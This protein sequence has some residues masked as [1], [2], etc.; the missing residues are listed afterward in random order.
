MVSETRSLVA[1][2]P[3]HFYASLWRNPKWD[4]CL[5]EII[6]VTTYSVISNYIYIYIHI[7]SHTVA[8]VFSFVSSVRE[9][10]LWLKK[11]ND[12]FIDRIL[13][14]AIIFNSHYFTLLSRFRAFALIYSCVFDHYTGCLSIDGATWTGW[15]YMR[16]NAIN[17]CGLRLC[18]RKN[19]LWISSEYAC[20]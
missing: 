7:F 14:S 3:V 17:F 20:T 16:K 2:F 10:H 4:V 6:T 5:F 11:W 15:L 13:C 9:I 8:R 18:S 12:I 1:F 19:R